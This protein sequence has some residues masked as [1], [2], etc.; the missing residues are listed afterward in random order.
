APLPPATSTASL[1]LGARKTPR[2]CCASWTT[3]APREHPPDGIPTHVDRRHHTPGSRR[4]NQARGSRTGRHESRL[5]R[6]CQSRDRGQP[7]TYTLQLSER[8]PIC[9]CLVL[10]RQG[11]GARCAEEPGDGGGGEGF[12]A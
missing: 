9:D 3:S 4:L 11:E 2:Q 6:R 1:P 8:D 12:G 7:V 5:R 10:R